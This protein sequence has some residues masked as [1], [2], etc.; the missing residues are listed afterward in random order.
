MFRIRVKT[1]HKNTAEDFRP[2]KTI[3]C[4]VAHVRSHSPCSSI[5]AK[6]GVR[7]RFCQSVIQQA[8]F[9]HMK[10]N[11]SSVREG[12]SFWADLPMAENY[13]HPELTPKRPATQAS[14]AEMTGSMIR[15]L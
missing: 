14:R 7:K 6:A 12:L 13:T 8:V 15:N 10:W 5:R 3:A 9:T 11:R 1:G 4:L 2:G